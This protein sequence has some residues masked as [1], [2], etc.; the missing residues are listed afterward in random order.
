MAVLFHVIIAL[1]SIAMASY[2]FFVPSNNT[3][4]VSY[5]L[6]A[7]TIIS[8]TY[9]VVSTRS[10]MIEACTVGLLYTGAMLTTLVFAR[11]KLAVAALND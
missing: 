8:G 5:G 9:L 2:A 3:L 7:A 10:H 4:R 1:G 11:R 6:V